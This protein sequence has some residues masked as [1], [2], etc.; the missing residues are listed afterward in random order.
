MKVIFLKH[1][2]NVGKEWE[3]KE[4]SDGYALNFLIPKNFAKKITPQ[5]ERSIKNKIQKKE[6]DRRNILGN[7]HKIIE[8]LNGKKFTFH[9]RAS[10]SGK[11]MWSVSEKDIIEYI[12]KHFHI[13]LTKKHISFSNGH[14]KT[15]WEDYIY[16]KLWENAAA[17]VIISVEKI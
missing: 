6:S 13:Q 4:V 8:E 10:P 14:I 17:K 11:L 12:K 7:K 1:I 2:A 3:I 16:I 9:F 15:L 5:M